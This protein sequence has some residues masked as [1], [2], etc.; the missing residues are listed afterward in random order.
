MASPTNNRNPA[1]V[2]GFVDLHIHS[3]HSGDGQFS[4][5]EIFH[6]A[7]AAGAGGIAISD[8][9]SVRGLQE[10]VVLAPKYAF[11]F[12]PSV[13]LT[14]DHEGREL[15][16]LGPFVE[17]ECRQLIQAIG[18]QGR[19]RF[20][21]ALERIARLRK[22]G[23]KISYEEA[24]A[25]SQ[26]T[27]P[28]GTMIAAAILGKDAGVGDPLLAQY[29]SGTRSDRPELRFYQDFMGKGAPAHVPCNWLGT[30]EAL[31]LLMSCGAVPILAHPG[32]GVFNVGERLIRELKEAGLKGLEVFTSYHDERASMYYLEIARKLNLIPSSG[33]DFHGRL[34]PHVAFGSVRSVG[35]ELIQVL[36]SC[37][38]APDSAEGRT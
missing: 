20:E 23:F 12:V 9:D 26:G 32:A 18:R 28:S 33:S 11:E 2:P 5:K 3:I 30:K 19:A 10:A 36:K 37:R 6:F 24:S 21:Q 13:E 31:E 35:P 34:K 27:T 15:H 29:I 8:H 16:V 4:P 1:A 22:I 14:T 38:R 17:R 25:A 7:E